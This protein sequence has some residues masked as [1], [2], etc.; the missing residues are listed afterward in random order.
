MTHVVK[1]KV[2]KHQRKYHRKYGVGKYQQY[3]YRVMNKA[4]ETLKDFNHKSDAKKYSDKK[5]GV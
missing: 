1:L 5:R 4:G 3:F 2:S